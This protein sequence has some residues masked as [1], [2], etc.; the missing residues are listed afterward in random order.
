MRNRSFSFPQITGEFALVIVRSVLGSIFITHGLARIYY[1]SIPEFGDFLNSQGIMTGEIVAWTITVGEIIGGLFLIS[2]YYIK[3]AV[4]FHITVVL[5]GI[6]LV[7]LQNGWFVVGHG[8]GGVE[9]SIL[10][11]AVL[12]YLYPK[13]DTRYKKRP[14]KF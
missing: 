2:G 12:I 4:I 8:Q 14:S 9:Y 13:K 7:H 10:I 5:A 3:Y 11:L 1:W 6:F